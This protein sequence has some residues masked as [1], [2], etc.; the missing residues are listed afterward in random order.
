M[1]QPQATVTGAI[2]GTWYL[3]NPGGGTDQIA[4]TFLGDGT[5]LV[6]DKGTP[7]RD[8]S[9]TSGIEW[10]TYTWNASTGAL[11]M[12]FAVNTDLQWGFS[13]ASVS[14]AVVSGDNITFTTSDGLFTMPRLTT[15]A[16][17]IAG[18][19]YAAPTNGGGSDQIAFTFLA[20]GTFLVADKGTTARD[21]SGKSGLEWGTY[22][23]NASTGAFTFSVKVNTDGEWGMSNSALTAA[24]VSG[25]TLTLKEGANTAI[26][27]TR[28][29]AVPATTSTNATITGTASADTLVGGNGDDT[30][31]GGAGNDTIDGGAGIDTALYSGGR[32]SYTI[33][34]G[35]DGRVTATAKTGTDGTDTLTNVERLK[36][37]DKT[38]NL[39]VGDTAKTVTAAQLNSVVE[40]YIAYVNRVP[41]ADG[42]QYWINQLK[43]GQSLNQIG[44]SFYGAALQ[45]S[46]LTGYSTNMSNG[47]FVTV[48]YKNV[49]G[50]S[51]PDAEGLA[52][53]STELASGRASRGTL[54]SSMLNSA[55][56]FKGNAQFGFV[57]DLL[58]NKI[59]VGKTFAIENG[60]VYNTPEDSIS[61]GMAI[62]AAVTATSTSAAISLIGVT[63]GLNLLA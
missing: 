23:W 46:S 29:S 19:W 6:A 10:G 41:D 5:F 13:N 62:S 25:D 52:Y 35:A 48:V 49:L 43:A 31:T 45:F 47:D 16:G 1:Q 28:V 34:R 39:T 36:F 8:P 20:D 38:I 61:Q 56:T 32:S 22:T 58:D 60:L 18:S 53:W 24:T 50:R 40:L 33:G 37:T 59:A 4:I 42:M 14:K 17:G 51:T 3:A 27:L 12:T 26:S 11:A 30:I 55:H 7:S 54:V 9:G 15:P 44:E 57:A 2:L 21:P 63:D